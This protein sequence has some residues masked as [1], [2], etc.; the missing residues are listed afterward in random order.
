MYEFA[1]TDI[2]CGY[3]RIEKKTDNAYDAVWWALEA[4][5]S[6]GIFCRVFVSFHG[7]AHTYRFYNFSQ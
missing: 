6:N 5:V 2:R 1:Y 4:S 7:Y 3:R